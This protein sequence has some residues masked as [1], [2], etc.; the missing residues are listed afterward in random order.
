MSIS[1][2]MFTLKAQEDLRHEENI[3]SYSME[4]TSIYAEGKSGGVSHNEG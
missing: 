2:N 4:T 3:D 1:V